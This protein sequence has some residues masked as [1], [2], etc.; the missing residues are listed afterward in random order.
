MS[1]SLCMHRIVTEPQTKPSRD[2]QRRLNHNIRDV[3]KKEVLKWLDAGIIYPISDSE[4]VSPTQTVPKKAD[5]GALVIAISLFFF[6]FSRM[7]VWGSPLLSVIFLDG[8][9][10]VCS[11]LIRGCS[12]RFLTIAPVIHLPITDSDSPDE[13]DSP[14]YITP[15][16]ATSPFLYT[17]SFEASDSFDGPSSQ[18]PYVATVARW[19]SRVTTRS[20]S[21]SNFPIAPVTAL[22]ADSEMS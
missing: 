2:A 16:L 6:D 15:L 12:R 7:R 10:Y 13:M 3:V 5:H 19:R 1:P 11:S 17:D 18:D 20:P 4:W 14:E 21:P 8:F 9:S 22:H